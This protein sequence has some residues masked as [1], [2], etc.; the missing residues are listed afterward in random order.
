MGDVFPCTEEGIGDAIA[1][2]GGVHTFACDGS[3][4]I[5][6]VAEIQIDNDVALDG[7]GNLT[8]DGNLGHPVFSVA[9]GVVAQLGGL[10]VTQGTPGIENRGRL[11][12]VNCTVSGNRSNPKI[13][14]PRVGGIYNEGSLTL[15]D[16]TVSGNTATGEQTL[17]DEV[18]GIFNTGPMTLINSTVSGNSATGAAT[19][20]TIF[21]I[22]DPL[23]LLHSTIVGNIYT[24]GGTITSAGSIIVGNCVSEEGSA[25]DWR[26]NGYNAGRPSCGFDQ[27]TDQVNVSADDL[28]LGPLQDNGG[29]TMTHALGAASIAIDVIPE[30]DCVDAEGEL[31]T[32]DQR[33]EPRPGGTMCDVGAFEVQP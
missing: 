33:G 10:T 13:E 28:K 25:G 16:T 14:Y 2:G 26:S 4:T 11:T 31:L 27:P 23:T 6:T 1:E 24:V 3:Q 17:G 29:P 22:R 32:T 15:R 9:P 5:T 12:L 30:A 21:N 19:V 18:G 8:V 7:E 20:D